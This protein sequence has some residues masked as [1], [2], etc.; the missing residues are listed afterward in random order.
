MA[1][2]SFDLENASENMCMVYDG[3]TDVEEILCTV[4]P[5]MISSNC[6]KRIG[7]L[8]EITYTECF[9]VKLE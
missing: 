6:K 4:Q 9:Y 3:C 8:H 2:F 5:G 7:R 1:F